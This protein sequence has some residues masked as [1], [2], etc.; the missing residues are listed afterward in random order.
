MSLL[1]GCTPR[2]AAAETRRGGLS[3]VL[4]AELLIARSV[5]ATRPLD[6]DS[7]SGE[8]RSGEERSQC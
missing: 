1:C 5:F 7:A 6:D 4:I 3:V 2:Y 8:E